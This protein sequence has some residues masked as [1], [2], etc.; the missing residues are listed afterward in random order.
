MMPGWL[1]V[2]LVIGGIFAIGW[3]W[4]SISDR[5]GKAGAAADAAERAVD[6]TTSFFAKAWGV[7]LV[8]LGIV[9][10]IFLPSYWW[11]YLLMIGYGVYLILPGEKW[12]VW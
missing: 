4:Q 7:V 10:F 1:T 2:V 9:G 5:G 3:V 11:A 12:V 8:L 6:A